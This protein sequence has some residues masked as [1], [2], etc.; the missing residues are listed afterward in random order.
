QLLTNGGSITLSG[1]EVMTATGSSMNLNGGYVHYDGGIVNTT[2][3][4]DA[5]GALVPIGQASPNDTY[6]G[7]AGQFVESHPRWGVTKTWY[8]PLLTMGGYQG[9]YIVGGNAGTLDIY[10]LQSTV[11]DGDISAQAFGGAKQMQG[12]S[13]PSGGTFN[14]GADP[15]L[16]G[17]ALVHLTSNNSDVASGTAGMVVLQ[18]NAPK[19]A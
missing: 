9:D 1:N 11:L 6:V 12:N 13:L 18:D 3:L 15:K 10:G 8:N 17:A 14:L 2:R 7:I 19:L 5:N 16:D 4:V